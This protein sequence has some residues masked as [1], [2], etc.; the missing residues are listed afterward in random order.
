MMSVSFQ[1]VSLCLWFISWR[2]PGLRYSLLYIIQI[3]KPMTNSVCHHH[4]T[5]QISINVNIDFWRQKKGCVMCV[6]NSQASAIDVKCCPYEFPVWQFQ[7]FLIADLQFKFVVASARLQ[8]V[9]F[10]ALAF[11]YFYPKSII[12]KHVKQIKV[13]PPKV[14]WLLFFDVSL[15]LSLIQFGSAYH[16][17][18]WEHLYIFAQFDPYY[19]QHTN[20]LSLFSNRV[21]TIILYD[22]IWFKSIWAWAIKSLLKSRY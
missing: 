1:L 2:L 13:P 6:W 21:C 3:H 12:F 15:R 8:V 22:W 4:Y 19:H 10:R 16:I 7:S 20:H 14:L 11:G 17:P 5:A 9:S 18:E